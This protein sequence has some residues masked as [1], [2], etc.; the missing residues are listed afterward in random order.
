MTAAHMN[1]REGMLSVA[2]QVRRT[3]SGPFRMLLS[4]PSRLT[5]ALRH[6]AWR[7]TALESANFGPYF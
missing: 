6:E 3:V 1:R 5:A 7:R 4:H 2:P